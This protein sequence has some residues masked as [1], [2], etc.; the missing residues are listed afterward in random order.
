VSV[1]E[2]TDIGSRYVANMIVGTLFADFSGDIFLLHSEVLD[3]VGGTTIT[4][5]FDKAVK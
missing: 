1:I 3:K 5:L 2:L 4:I